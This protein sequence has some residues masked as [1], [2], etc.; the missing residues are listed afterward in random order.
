MQRLANFLFPQKGWGFVYDYLCFHAD[1]FG[2]SVKVNGQP[3]DTYSYIFLCGFAWAMLIALLVVLG[4]VA[5]HLI[6]AYLDNHNIRLLRPESNYLKYF[7]QKNSLGKNLLLADQIVF[8]ALGSTLISSFFSEVCVIN[9]PDR[10][11]FYKSSVLRYLWLS[12]LFAVFAILISIWYRVAKRKYAA[13]QIVMPSINAYLNQF[14]SGAELAEICK[15]LASIILKRLSSN[16]WKHL[17][18]TI[19]DVRVSSDDGCKFIDVI[20]GDVFDIVNPL[21]R[22]LYVQDRN[23]ID[24]IKL[25]RGNV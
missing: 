17:Y 22:K 6:D 5:R 8:T 18:Y 11:E 10:I 15:S 14:F 12:L 3:P 25:A 7:S 19:K 16:T 13:Q 1:F 4:H 24:Q 9:T 21:Y 2:N 20:L 23:L